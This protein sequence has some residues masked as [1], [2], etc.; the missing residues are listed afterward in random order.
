VD[1]RATILMA[2]DRLLAATIAVL[3]VGSAVCFGG[4]VWW[5]RPAA[6]FLAFL[7]AGGKL[8]QCLVAG[9][10]PF[11]KSPLLLLGLLALSLGV[12]Q[13]V[14]LPQNVARRLSPG[15]HEIYACGVMPGL[16]RSD[17]PSVPQIEEAHVRSPATLDRSATLR[18][19]FAASVCLGVFWVVSHFVDRRS[20]LFLVWGSLVAAFFVNAALG[21][22]Q[23][24]GQADG[25]YG[26]LQPGRSPVWAP[27]SCDLLETPSS[28]VLRRLGPAPEAA[29]REPLETVALVPEREF[30]FGTMLGGAG[31]FLALGSLA[32][33]LALAVL[34]YVVSPRGS[35]EN[36]ASRLS[37][38]GQGSLV[39]LLAVMLVAS[40]FLIG[41]L[42]GPLFCIPFGV[43]IAAVGLP[44]AAVGRWWSLGLSSL[45]AVCLGLGVALSAA[46]PALFGGPPPV[47]PVSWEASR[48][49]WG[50]SLTI[51]ESFPI[52]GTGF[53]SF[54]SMHP[55]AKSHDSSS[56]TAMSSLLQWA[57]E[58]GAV[59]ICL[60]AVA[61]LWSLCRLP[62]CLARVGAADRPLAYGS[63]GAV[64]GFGLWSTVHWTIDLPAVAVA[65][66]ALF[67][68]WN[69]WL[70]GGTD[71]FVERG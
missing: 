6:V 38:S 57:V 22:V 10:L 40:S 71:L 23:V 5:Y 30:Q 65:A 18:W 2:T 34:L 25:M 4:A 53:G 70:A 47:S 44:S 41:F 51:L 66:S 59:G 46:W 45:L 55:Y 11:L 27:S 37:H 56:T 33:P 28:A 16:V 63:I 31:S 26:Y 39:V 35:R 69:R 29:S 9:R 49:V 54:G 3:L 50:E 43:A 21:V 64:L 52:V 1:P 20:R 12:V 15:A 48:L 7:L 13:L 62:S 8:L 14:P 19:L 17:L 60:V 36:L 32:L 67:G 42:A 58:S 24:A 61:G 68:T